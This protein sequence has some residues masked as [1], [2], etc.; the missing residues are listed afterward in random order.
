MYSYRRHPPTAWSWLWLQQGQ[1]FPGGHL[2]GSRWDSSLY[3]PVHC[4]HNAQA[5]EIRFR[6]SIWSRGILLPESFKF[7]DPSQEETMTFNLLQRYAPPG[8]F[9]FEMFAILDYAKFLQSIQ[10]K[11]SCFIPPTSA[12]IPSVSTWLLATYD[13]QYHSCAL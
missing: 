6:V 7:L 5:W 4:C 9:R 8:P 1:S 13:S 3:L 10:T 12:S 2:P 11:S